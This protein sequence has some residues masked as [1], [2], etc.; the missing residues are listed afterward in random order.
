MS[1]EII[2]FVPKAN[3]KREEAEQRVAD[4]FNNLVGVWPD[5]SAAAAYHAPEKDPA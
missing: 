4:A 1:A 5:F 3:P 2:Q